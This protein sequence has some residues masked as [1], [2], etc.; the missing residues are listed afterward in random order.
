MRNLLLTLLTLVPMLVNA[1][2]FNYLADGGG[3]SFDDTGRGGNGGS[4]VH[5][6][7]LRRGNHIIN[8]LLNDPNGIKLAKRFEFDIN[9]VDMKASLTRA[10]VR[11]TN[12]L[13]QCKNGPCN[14]KTD[15]GLSFYHEKTWKT[16]FE[17][18]KDVNYLILHEMIRSTTDDNGLND[19]NFQISFNIKNFYQLYGLNR[20][21]RYYIAPATQVS[22]D[23]SEKRIIKFNINNQPIL[24]S[25]R[26]DGF[27]D[28]EIILACNSVNI[29][30]NQILST[31]PYSYVQIDPDFFSKVMLK[32]YL[33]PKVEYDYYE[34][35]SSLPSV[36]KGYRALKL[37]EISR[38]TDDSVLIWE[39]KLGKYFWKN[40]CFEIISE[41]RIGRKTTGEKGVHIAFSIDDYNLT[42]RHESLSA[43]KAFYKSIKNRI[44]KE[45]NA[46]EYFDKVILGRKENFFKDPNI[47]L[48]VFA[49]TVNIIAETAEEY[50][51][52]H[53][54]GS[55]V[56]QAANQIL[57]FKK[58]LYTASEIEN[59]IETPLQVILNN[60]WE[61][62]ESGR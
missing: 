4:D 22:V 20:V 34:E 40:S 19:D 9:P 28:H 27:P 42:S 38:S 54:Y 52:K 41:I 24:D 7:I 35:N 46:S 30:L 5:A 12:D 36:I 37:I 14:A 47:C 21:G 58:D 61:K 62:E 18:N 43:P 3:G 59:D 55:E 26:I 53:G 17:E 57:S 32:P 44:E 45:L 50:E 23:C 11:M 31:N 39:S 48:K 6:E 49:T 2:I 25:G 13:L 1:Q 8:Y 10:R 56:A 29:Q 16:F 33:P 15:Y 51:S 60:T